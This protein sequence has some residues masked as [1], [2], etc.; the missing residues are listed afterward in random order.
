MDRPMKTI[1]IGMAVFLAMSLALP[2]VAH[3]KAE[4]RQWEDQW[5]EQ[6]M[7]RG[8]TPRLLAKRADFIQRHAPPKTTRRSSSSTPY[9]TGMGS[10]VEKWRGLVASYFSDVDRALCLMKHESGGNPTATSYA[11]ARGLMQVMPFWAKHLG[12]AV[13]SLY[14]PETNL[15]VAS[16]VYKQQ[17]WWAWSPYKRG[18][19]R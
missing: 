4:Q 15:R 16:Y 6:V 9:N 18:E 8:V 1:T 5:M 11:G 12:I 19:C 17:G 10:G 13:D 14:E 7:I 2:A 3:T